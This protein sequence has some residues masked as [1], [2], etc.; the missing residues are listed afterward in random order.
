MFWKKKEYIEKPFICITCKQDAVSTCFEECE[1]CNKL[2]HCLEGGSTKYIIE[3]I[4][5]RNYAIEE[6]GLDWYIM[7]RDKIHKK[8]ENEQKIIQEQKDLENKNKFAKCIKTIEGW[9]I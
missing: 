9:K 1:E 7:A 8:I 3:L 5:I 4:Y 2:Y 6:K